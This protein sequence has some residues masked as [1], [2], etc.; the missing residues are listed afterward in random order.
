MDSI[1]FIVALLCLGLV[2][3]W[4]VGNEAS[5]A[6]GAWGLLAIFSPKAAEG[7]DAGP[8]YQPAERLTPGRRERSVVEKAA[9][10]AAVIA[11]PRFAAK[12]A[13]RFLNKDESGYRVRGRLPMADDPPR[14]DSDARDAG[15]PLS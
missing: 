10:S 4:Y 5:S 2:A 7:G 6:A 11:G 9:A 8:R 12:G 15:P 1:L 3:G 14:R 13:G